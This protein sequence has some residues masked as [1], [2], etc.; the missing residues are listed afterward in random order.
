MFWS[1]PSRPK[2]EQAQ[3]KAQVHLYE[4]FLATIEHQSHVLHKEHVIN[5]TSEK[6]GQLSSNPTVGSPRT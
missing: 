5:P 6:S 1:G 4:H 2:D 3:L